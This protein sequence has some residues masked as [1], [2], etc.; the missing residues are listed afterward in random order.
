MLLWPR[1]R[2][3]GVRAR[4]W[5]L[6]RASRLARNRAYAWGFVD[7]G[8]SSATNLGLTLL[9]GR[10]L[11][12]GGLGVV[13]IAFAVYLLILAFQRALL[14]D[15]LVSSSAARGSDDRSLAIRRGLTVDLFGAM[16]ATLLVVVLGV[17]IDGRAGRGLLIIAPWLLPALVQ[18]FWRTIL[19][20]ERRA[21]AAAA[22]DA[23][24][25]LVMVL[26]APLAWVLDT[27]WAM[28]ACW[29]SGALAGALLGFAQT[30]I[31]PDAPLHAF[32]WWR[33]RLWPFGRWL[34]VEGMVY[35]LNS[36]ATVFLL[37]G[38]LGA[39]ALG[40]LRAAQSLFAPL[41]LLL[42]AIS[43]PGLPAMA[44]SL[45]A[46]PRDAIGLA[47]RLSG[48]V[49]ALATLYG[50]AMIVSG[51]NLIVLVFG[52]SFREYT[53]LA[54]PIGVWQVVAGLSV[55]FTLFL[56]AQQRGRDLLLV[57]VAGSVG[58]LVFVPFLA[59][60]NGVTGAAWG[61]S[62]YAAVATALSAALAF[63]SY[64]RTV[65]TEGLRL[66]DAGAADSCGRVVG[67]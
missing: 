38:L 49:T 48:S 63:R 51:G 56:T 29:G 24:W 1:A 42:P 59:W 36:S 32:A 54:V 34:G 7:Q 21:A 55:G 22:N 44:R 15:P 13:V 26:T 6:I 41:S 19:F 64:R 5:P 47:L 18:D 58:C 8:F 27:E 40:G 2:D 43:L 45:A 33:T 10:A 37:N 50:A 12:P 31:R 35:A 4:R 39:K 67:G 3:S 52:T 23:C 30:H 61:F 60:A 65:R 16:G 66:A 25:A 20:Q 57:G 28:A 53:D 11:G 9:A 14:T 17:T 62:L 46:S